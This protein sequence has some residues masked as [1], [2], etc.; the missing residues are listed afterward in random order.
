MKDLIRK[1]LR[2]QI[3]LNKIGVEVEPSDRVVK[4]ICD[5]EKFCSAQGPITFGQLRAIVE[6]A[7]KKRIALH[8]GEGTYKAFL[9]LLPFFIPQMSVQGMVGAVIRA[10][11]KIFGPTIT[12]TTSYKKWW[13]KAILKVFKMSE[14]EL[15]PTDPFSRIFFISDGLMNLMD[16]ENKVKFARHIA[17]VASKMPND[18]P[19]PDMFVENELRQWINKRFL[20]DPPLEPKNIKEAIVGDRIVCDDCGWAWKIEEGGD[21]LYMCHQCGH[22]NTPQKINE[23][24]KSPYVK[25][26]DKYGPNIDD[27]FLWAFGLQGITP[28]IGKEFV[29]YVG[30]HDKLLEKAKEFFKYKFYHVGDGERDGGYDFNF[31]VE[32]GHTRGPM[33]KS[34]NQFRVVVINVN[35]VDNGT[36]DLIFN[37]RP[38]TEWIS[39]IINDDEIGYEIEQEIKDLVFDRILNDLEGRFLL[40]PTINKIKFIPR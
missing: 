5:A 12:E 37:E 27:D 32:I 40:Q 9:R 15:N 31:N 34:D 33:T 11:H 17:E 18:E 22:D 35:I 25:Y 4:S 1:V 6:H 10:S 20:L 26:W 19:V 39:E 23:S 29:D 7:M 24:K 21:D 36:V 38:T 2:E 8:V 28:E 14:G 3:D 30:G 13:G 16:E